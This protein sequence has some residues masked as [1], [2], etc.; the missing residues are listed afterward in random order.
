MLGQ[1]NKLPLQL[2]HTIYLL[3][4][5]S[6]NQPWLAAAVQTSSVNRFNEPVKPLIVPI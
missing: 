3:G 5:F 2:S 4:R 1:S 6:T